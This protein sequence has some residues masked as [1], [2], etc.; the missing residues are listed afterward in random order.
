MI[1]G[2]KL[3]LKASLLALSFAILFCAC[4]CGLELPPGTKLKYE[5]VAQVNYGAN[6]L[7]YE[8]GLLMIT[9]RP[10]SPVFGSYRA[11]NEIL[12]IR[13]EQ[14][15][16]LIENIDYSQ[17]FV[18]VVFH[19]E[20]Y[21]L[22]GTPASPM[23]IYKVWQNSDDIYIHARFQ[24]HVSFPVIPAICTPYIIMKVLKDS[25]TQAGTINFTLFD[26]EGQTKATSSFDLSG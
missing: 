17:Y 2:S 24:P 20:T 4:S 11:G 6:E 5:I 13:E 9:S 12:I 14:S 21:P 10:T 18:I 8:P 3:S 26:R 16:S 19:S 23:K 22:E 7:A 1:K 15:Q 25:L